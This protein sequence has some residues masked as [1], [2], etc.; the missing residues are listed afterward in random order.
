MMQQDLCDSLLR[1]IK[2]SR[3]ATFLESKTSSVTC[4]EASS[5]MEQPHLTGSNISTSQL[6][7]VQ[8]HEMKSRTIAGLCWVR[9]R[10]FHFLSRG[11]VMSSL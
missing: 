5:Q 1:T 11:A 3:P 9:G 10:V 2:L 6:F 4:G 8:A 7:F